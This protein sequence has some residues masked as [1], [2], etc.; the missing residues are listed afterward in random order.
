[1]DIGS[2]KGG[3]TDGFSGFRKRMMSG[4][5]GGNEGKEMDLNDGKGCR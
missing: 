5:G 3:E 1:M 4:Y 2:V